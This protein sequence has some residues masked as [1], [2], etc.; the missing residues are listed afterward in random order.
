MTKIIDFTNCELSTRNLEYGG[1]AGEKKGILYNGEFWFLKF[2]KSTVGMNKVNGISYV[3]SPISE[4][5]GSHIYE[6]LGYDVHKT[7]LG[8][9]Y[10]GK[11]NKVICACKDFINDDKNELLIN[12]TSLRNDTNPIVMER[13]DEEG[14][15]ASNINEI[16]FQLNN[17]TIL[18]E[19]DNAKQRFWDVVVI[20]AL[21]NNNDRN[22]D[23]WGVIKFK[24]ENKYIMA[25]I[26][27]CGNSFYGKT[28]E[29]R[30]VEI[31][32]DQ[33]KLRSSSLNGITAYED[34]DDNRIRLIDIMNIDNEDLKESIVRVA[35][36]ISEHF[37]EI[38]NF[39]SNIPC[40][41]EGIEIISEN[42][43]KYYIETIKLR[44]NEL[45]VKNIQN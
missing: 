1:R 31:L 7:L 24:K 32:S 9:C 38:V 17:N 5:I 30:I 8:V 40:I 25:P 43:K 12:Y 36:N 33:V 34:D 23:N 26:Y 44:F 2:P 39:I 28:S 22:E 42:R 13:N 11:R 35:N 4:Y 27:D 14:M 37:D 6:I 29:E 10:D 45:I 18:S 3:T 15:S 41:Y 19:I 16:I 21:I 20:D